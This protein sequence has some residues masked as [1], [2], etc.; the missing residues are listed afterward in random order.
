[1]D[2]TRKNGQGESFNPDEISPGQ[3]GRRK[4]EFAVHV[5]RSKLLGESS[6]SNS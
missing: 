4:S 5:I 1:M 2:S 6:D 3:L